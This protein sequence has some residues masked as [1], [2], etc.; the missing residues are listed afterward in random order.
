MFDQLDLPSLRLGMNPQL[1]MV[2]VPTWFWAEGYDGNVIPLTDN[3]VLSHDECNRIVD[4]DSAGNVV[5]DEDGAPATHRECRTITDTL[6]VEVRAWPRSYEWT[7]G[8]D[9]SMTIDCGGIGACT[10]GLGLPYTN[11]RTPSPIAHAYRWTS[12]GKNGDAD[13][14]TIHLAIT[15][16]AQFQFSTNGESRSGWESLD[17][18]ELAWSARHRVQ[19][20]QSVLT[21]P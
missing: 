1:G 6:T 21:R 16:G 14:Y 4:R 9:H 20:A 19:Q 5:L 12:L 15:F 3:L 18:R 7:F 2:A 8:D 10:A 17:D 11:P 13:A